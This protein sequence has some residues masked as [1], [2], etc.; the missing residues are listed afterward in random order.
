MMK[1]RRTVCAF[2]M[3][4]IL[5]T[6]VVIWSSIFFYLSFSLYGLQSKGL[7]TISKGKNDKV[8]YMYISGG[9]FCW[10]QMLSG[11]ANNLRS[12][13]SIRKRK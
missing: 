6:T 3:H 13:S 7:F 8:K 2:S 5:V 1:P 11:K 9:R 12:F 4:C 10:F